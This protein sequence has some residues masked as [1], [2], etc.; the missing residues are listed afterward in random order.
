MASLVRI[1]SVRLL[2]ARR[3]ELTLTNGATKE[4][5][6]APLLV[7]PV[8]GAILHDD[9]AFAQVEVDTEF[10]SLVW[11]SGADLCPDVLIQDRQP[12]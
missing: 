7:G 1:S 4:V 9:A 8:F 10:G 5:D 6:L 3:V 2:G 12:A 11:P